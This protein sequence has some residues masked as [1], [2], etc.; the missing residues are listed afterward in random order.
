MKRIMSAVSVASLAFIST[1]AV[2]AGPTVQLI[3]RSTT[4]TGT[5]GSNSI[6][7]NAGDELAL[8][9]R[10]SGDGVA[11]DGLAGVSLSLY[12]NAGSLSGFGAQ[13]CPSPE[14]P[15]A[16]I[17]LDANDIPFYVV[18]SGVAEAAGSAQGFDAA[19]QPVPF[20]AGYLCGDTMYLGRTKFILSGG[21]NG[22]TIPITLGYR[23]GIDGILDGS[24]DFWGPAGEATPVGPGPAATATVQRVVPGC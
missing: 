10:V 3:W 1:L 11:C 18:N 7:A 24:G 19:T 14:N 13:E 22:Q 2:A 15:G 9:I 16:G 23:P 17:C 12:W 6:T 8:D 21:P 5:P 4:G 20:T